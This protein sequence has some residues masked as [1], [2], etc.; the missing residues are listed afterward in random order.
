MVSLPS[1][2]PLKKKVSAPAAA[3]E[4]VVAVADVE[5]VAARCR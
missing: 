5:G 3:G 1:W 2:L 4:G